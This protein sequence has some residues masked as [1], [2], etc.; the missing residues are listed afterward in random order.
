[1]KNLLKKFENPE[2]LEQFCKVQN[3]KYKFTISKCS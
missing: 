2:K 1:M 3:Y